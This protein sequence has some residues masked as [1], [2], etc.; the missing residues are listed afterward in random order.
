MPGD[1]DQPL[2]DAH[3]FF[4][5]GTCGFRSFHPDGVL[6]ADADG[7]F[8]ADRGHG[9]SFRIH[10]GMRFLISDAAGG[11]R[12]SASEHTVRHDDCA[13]SDARRSAGDRGDPGK[14]PRKRRSGTRQVSHLRMS[15]GDR[16]RAGSWDFWWSGKSRRTSGRFSTWRWTRRKAAGEWRARCS[17]TELQRTKN[18]VVFRGAG[19][20][21]R[22][23]S[24]LYQNAGFRV[25]G[26]R[27]SYY[28]DPPESGIVMKFNS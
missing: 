14:R 13:C 18:A 27:E 24:A 1:F 28:S 16:W 23:P 7:A 9:G 2:R 15:G 3:R 26:R 19:V 8:A 21:L 20:Q 17:E 4:R 5:R 12:D 6:W 25:A 11:D 22:A 10:G